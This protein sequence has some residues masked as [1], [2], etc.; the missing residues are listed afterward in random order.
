MALINSCVYMFIYTTWHHYYS[1]LFPVLMVVVNVYTCSAVKDS[2]LRYK[3]GALL[4][5]LH[6]LLSYVHGNGLL[7]PLGLCCY[8][9]VSMVNLPNI[10]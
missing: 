1:L 5:I 4:I 7:A 6:Q 9:N 2:S 3:A 10:C 8:K